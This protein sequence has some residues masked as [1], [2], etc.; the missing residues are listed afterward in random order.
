MI[1]NKL[2]VKTF[3]CRAF[4]ED[5]KI[6]MSEKEF[7]LMSNPPLFKYYCEKCGKE[8]TSRNKYP[9]QECIES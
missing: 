8:D 2:E 4:C 1:V 3:I 5:C 7:M 6:E 9:R